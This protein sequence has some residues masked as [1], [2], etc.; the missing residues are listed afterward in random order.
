[1]VSQD[2]LHAAAAAAGFAM[3]LYE[4]LTIET[5]DAAS[6]VDQPLRAGMEWMP[7]LKREYIWAKSAGL[8]ETIEA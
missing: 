3:L 2:R 7:R 1:M 5:L 8:I 6:R 4:V